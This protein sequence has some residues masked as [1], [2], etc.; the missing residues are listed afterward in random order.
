MNQ[1]KPEIEPV[2]LRVVESDI[3][4]AVGYAE[5][6]KTLVVVSN[7]G[8]IYHYFDVP[9]A[10]YETLVATESVDLF[11]RESVMGCYGCIQIK[12]RG[13]KRHR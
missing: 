9:K 5:P 10:V 11:L 1:L 6:S 7:Q 8:K 13:R 12:R 2:R 4:Y 3:L